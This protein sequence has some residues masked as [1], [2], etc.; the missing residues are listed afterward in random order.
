M[1]RIHILMTNDDG[2]DAPGIKALALAVSDYARVTVVAPDRQRS[3]CSSGLT[4][5]SFF[6][7]REEMGYGEHIRVV[8]CEGNACRLL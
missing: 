6:S 1:K 3:S 7:C 4:L 8:F 2:Y 5:R